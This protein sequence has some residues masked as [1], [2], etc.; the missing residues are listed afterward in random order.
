MDIRD[1]QSQ[2]TDPADESRTD[3]SSSS[4][5]HTERPLDDHVSL[6]NRAQAL[7]DARRAALDVPDVRTDR[8]EAL[9]RQIQTGSL[10]PDPDR[11]ARALLG[12]G[13]VEA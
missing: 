1:V 4:A 3:G 10:V 6:S 9:R 12:Q 7:Q 8:V 11:I 2:G 5:W 13:A